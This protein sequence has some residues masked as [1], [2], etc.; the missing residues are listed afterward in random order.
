MESR[1]GEGSSLKVDNVV[2]SVNDNAAYQRFWP[3]VSELWTLIGIHPKLYWVTE[4]NLEF[5][6][7]SSFGSIEKVGIIKGATSFQRSILA[8]L[9]GC[10]AT[11]GINMISDIDLLPISK[12]YYLDTVAPYPE[13]SL[14]H[15]SSELGYLAA[16]NTLP[17]CYFIG[18]QEVFTK[19]LLTNPVAFKGTVSWDENFI[20]ELFLI[21][22]VA[23]HSHLIENNEELLFQKLLQFGYQQT[24]PRFPEQPVVVILPRFGHRFWNLDVLADVTMHEKMI[25]TC[26]D[27]HFSGRRVE[28]FQFV[29]AF[30]EAIKRRLANV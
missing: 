27:A 5:P 7:P 6:Y 4:S 21:T 17:A 20:Q 14:V 8:R 2:M 11:A 9:Y 1:N 15:L 19:L 28:N 29:E 10:S 30:G 12:R 13:T 23:K 22:K 18:K 16:W 24:D 26:W 3:I 25:D